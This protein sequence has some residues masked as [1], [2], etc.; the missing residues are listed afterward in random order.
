MKLYK[1]NETLQH[2]YYQMPQELFCNEKYKKLSI[3][4]KVI[5]A[6]LLNR[7]N[8]SR[9]NKWINE[10][11]EI[12]LI[13]TRKEIQSKLN[14]S[15]KPVTRAFKELREANL[16]KEEKQGFGKPNLIYIGKIKQ[17]ELQINDIDIDDYTEN[18][19]ADNRI[20]EDYCVGKITILETENL[21]ANKKDNKKHKNNNIDVSQLE[22]ETK[23]LEDIKQKCELYLF[24][25][26]QRNIIENTLDLMF[27][28]NN[29]KIGQAVLPQEVVRSRMQLLNASIIF[30]AFD[31]LNYLKQDSKIH[32]ST[33]F[34]ISCLYNAI[35][36]YY[37]DSD[38]QFRIDYGS[39]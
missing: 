23:K 32:N 7:M 17:E 25:E 18:V 31:K 34:M 3:E 6:F 28:S 36:E 8:L 33:N 37:S 24:K 26:N 15:D 5:Y 30:Y 1:I 29:L 38:L 21:R 12:Y 35:T 19:L 22:I 10:K 27:Y 14:L 2:S 11:G 4:A 20:K 39:G 13:Y 16:I 9:M